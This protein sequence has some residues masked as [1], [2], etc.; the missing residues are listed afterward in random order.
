MEIAGQSPHVMRSHD[1]H[2]YVH[3]GALP[4]AT[5]TDSVCN[6]LSQR[7]LRG[8]AVER[9][10]MEVMGDFIQANSSFWESCLRCPK[11]TSIVSKLKAK[12]SERVISK[13]AAAGAYQSP[14]TASS[15]QIG[16]TQGKGQT[17]L[18]LALIVNK[19][20]RRTLKGLKLDQLEIAHDMTVVL[21]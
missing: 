18:G 20:M 2:V 13:K 9:H 5:G 3:P 19:V 16:P 12:S 21:A 15:T 17:R 7:A 10:D 6:H 8:A 4:E 1:K 14:S 11:M